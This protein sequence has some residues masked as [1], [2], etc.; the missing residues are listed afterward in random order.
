[1]RAGNIIQRLEASERN[2]ESQAFKKSTDM[3]V[4]GHIGQRYENRSLY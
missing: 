1:M 2:G 3:S 4:I